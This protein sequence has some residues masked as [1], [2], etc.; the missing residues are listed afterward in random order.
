MRSV[1]LVP[2]QTRLQ[3]SKPMSSHVQAAG[4]PRHLPHLANRSDK[5]CFNALQEPLTG[6]SAHEVG[7]STRDKIGP[8][9]MT[10]R[11][12][13]C[14]RQSTLTVALVWQ[15]GEDHRT[16]DRNFQ[17]AD[18]KRQ[19]IATVRSRKRKPLWLHVQFLPPRGEATAGAY[20]HSPASKTAQQR[21]RGETCSG[22]QQEVS[23]L[24]CSDVAARCLTYP[25]KSGQA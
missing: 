10:E 6:T 11:L 16:C 1:Y 17:N 23:I 18:D 19:C 12:L 4:D 8:S 15:Q 25:F 14:R 2:Q 7:R 9:C 5:F 24:L 21:E 3:M 22:G 20:Q 13:C